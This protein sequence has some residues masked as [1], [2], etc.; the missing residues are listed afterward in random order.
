MQFNVICNMVASVNNACQ[1]YSV[2]Q[3]HHTP[4]S[5]IAG[6]CSFIV[7]NQLDWLPFFSIYISNYLSFLYFFEEHFLFINIFP[8]TLLYLSFPSQI[9]KLS[10]FASILLSSFFF[11]PISFH[12]H[13]LLYNSSAFVLL[14]S[15][16][17][18]L[19]FTL[20]SL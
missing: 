20:L 9:E 1:G 14:T 16:L 2:L 4:C 3:L 5:P 17:P 6:S 12:H 10:I 11:S 13:L 15:P 8:K 7:Q 19:M 18:F